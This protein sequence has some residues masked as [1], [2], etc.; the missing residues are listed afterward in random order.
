MDFIECTGLFMNL[1]SYS[2]LLRWPDLEQFALQ[3]C[4]ESESENLTMEAVWNDVYHQVL[5]Q[6]I[7]SV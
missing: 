6:A 5:M 7:I 1:Q 3:L 2:K 4:H